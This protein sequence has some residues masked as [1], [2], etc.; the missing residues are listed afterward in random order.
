MGFFCD[1]LLVFPIQR[2]VDVVALSQTEGLIDYFARTPGNEISQQQQQPPRRPPPYETMMAL[3]Y[4]AGPF[5][6]SFFARQQ[7]IHTH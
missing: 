1:H 5:S 7:R 4:G 2:H 6:F 3:H